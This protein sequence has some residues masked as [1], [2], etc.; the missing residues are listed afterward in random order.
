MTQADLTLADEL[1]VSPA[2]VKTLAK[3]HLI[4]GEDYTTTGPKAYTA[5]GRQKLREMISSLSDPKKEKGG[6]GS[7]P[8]AAGSE[9]ASGVGDSE[10]RQ[11]PPPEPEPPS[12]PTV[13]PAGAPPPPETA[14]IN[15]RWP[16]PTLIQVKRS[17][18]ELVDVRVRKKER[19]RPGLPLLIAY[20]ANRWVA[21]DPAHTHRSDV[22]ALA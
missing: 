2:V 8:P 21:A 9:P 7:A 6:E 13:A 5:I 17:N 3:N 18:G 10:S 20:R 12:G 11:S 14:T 16:N 19:C 15:R 22:P 4:A 1:G